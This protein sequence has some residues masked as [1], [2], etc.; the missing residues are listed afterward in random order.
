M[1]KLTF[2]REEK[3]IDNE[4][5]K[6]TKHI[7]ISEKKVESEPAYVKM[8]VEDVVRI[9]NLPGGAGKVLNVLVKNMTYSNIVVLINPIKRKI[10]EE[11]GLTL[12]TINKAITQLNDA[13][14]LIRSE[15]S[16]YIVDPT[17]FAKGRWQDIK[18]LQ[19]TIT[20]GP[21]GKKEISSNAVSQLK[22]L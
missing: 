6:I 21:D 13:G 10:V 12:N 1:G 14:I 2:Q 11:T 5:G 17:L 3:Q 8:Y 7:V 18:Q 4:T 15:R 22:M 19:L 16:V 20:Y 9:N